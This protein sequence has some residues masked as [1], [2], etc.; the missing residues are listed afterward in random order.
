MIEVNTDNLP[1]GFKIIVEDDELRLLGKRSAEMMSVLSSGW[2]NV[3]YHVCDETGLKHA[4]K[5]AQTLTEYRKDDDCL[6][7]AIDKAIGEVVGDKNDYTVISQYGGMDFKPLV[8][9]AIKYYEEL[10]GDQNEA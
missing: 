6:D 4:I 2:W 8:R 3:S 1:E 10:R 7:K 5:Y 9:E